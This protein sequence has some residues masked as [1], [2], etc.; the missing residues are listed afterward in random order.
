M[1]E[2]I[3]KNEI[4]KLAGSSSL[5]DKCW[6]EIQTAYSKPNRHYHN[7]VHL[8]YLITNLSDIQNSLDDWQTIVLSV[9]YHDIVYNTLKQDNEKRSANIAVTRLS[10]LN[11]PQWQKDKCYSQIMATKTHHFV[12]DSDTNYFTDADLAVLGADSETYRLYTEQIR[13]EYHFYPDLVYNPGRKKVLKHF[14]AMPAIYKTPWFSNKFE[15]Q[16]RINLQNE[17]MQ[18]G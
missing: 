10:L 7:L 9:A 15:K 14:L 1:F 4:T 3:F 17:L 12:E 18:L 13:K 11:V 5:P 16:A 2:T 6:I 8:D